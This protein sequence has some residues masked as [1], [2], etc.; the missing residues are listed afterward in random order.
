MTSPTIRCSS[1]LRQV[2]SARIGPECS[3]TSAL[4][5]PA[6]AIK[7]KEQA[8]PKKRLPEPRILC[9]PFLLSA[10]VTTR[11]PIRPNSLTRA[12]RCHRR[13]T[14]CRPNGRQI[15]VALPAQR[16]V[17][18]S[19]LATG[20][21]YEVCAPH[22]CRPSLPPHVHWCCRIARRVTV[23]PLGTATLPRGEPYRW[24]G[25]KDNPDRGQC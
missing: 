14:G 22:R 2:V 10:A 17:R 16:R 3:M 25:S 4:R 8:I 9:S 6:R 21:E 12:G 13:W 20:K 24:Q 19:E 1:A 15:K 23:R 7:P 18:P 5:P 11:V